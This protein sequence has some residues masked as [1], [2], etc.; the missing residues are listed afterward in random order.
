[1][2][3]LLGVSEATYL[4]PLL[5]GLENPGSSR[6][7]LVDIPAK[8]ALNFRERIPPYDKAGCVFLSPI[9]YARYGAEY[10]ILPGVGVSSSKPT[11]TIQLF[12]KTDAR[13]IDTLAVDIRV[14]SEIILAKIL[15]AE[16][17]PNLASDPRKMQFI[18][19]LPDVESML[20]RADAALVVNFAPQSA[21][22]HGLFALDLVEEWNDLTNLPYVHGF[23]VGRE[24]AQSVTLLRRLVRAKGEGLSHVRDIASRVAAE[25]RVTTEL[26]LEYLSSFSYGLGKE[27]EEGLSEF[28]RFAFFHGIIPDVP[29]VNYFEMQPG[30]S[31]SLN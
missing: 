16:K 7:L 10:R 27:E 31:P 19:M 4:K 5:F 20:K 14:T 11:G 3:H 15:L 9:D 21:S 18:P 24:E 1:M 23:W 28:M 13:N 17:F 6:E 30:P 29:D 22:T 8:L 25:H 12:V 26:A 2:H